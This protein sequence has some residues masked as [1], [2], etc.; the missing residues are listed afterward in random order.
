MDKILKVSLFIT[1]RIGVVNRGHGW[2]YQLV[3][4]DKVRVSYSEEG[5]RENVHM[6]SFIGGFKEEN[7]LLLWEQEDFESLEK[8]A[9][10]RIRYYNRLRQY[11][12]S[13]NKS[14]IKYL[15][16]KGKIPR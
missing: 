3:V 4:K 14:P 7:R 9:G 8:V 1:T 5:V 6:E 10:Q 13:G 12:A 11:S 16:E 15:K 2:L